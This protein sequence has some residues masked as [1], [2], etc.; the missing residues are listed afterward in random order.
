MATSYFIIALS[1]AVLI[2]YGFD[3]LS[4]RFRT[5][6]VLLLLMLGA[7][8]RLLTNSLGITVPFVPQT[9]STLGTL[10]LILIVLEGGLDL[11]IEPGRYGLIRRTSLMGLLS[12]VA[13]TLLLATLLYILLDESYYKCL[14]NTLPF[15]IISSS[16]AGQATRPLTDGQREFMTYETSFAAIISIMLY[17][18]LIV[19][20]Q[21][22]LTATFGFV[23]DTLLMGVISVIC[24]FALLYLIGRINHPVKFLP[25]IS[26][27]FLVYAIADIYELS[28]LVLVLIFGLFLNNTELFIRGRLADVFKSDLFERELDQLKN[29]TA[30]GAFIIRTFFFLLFGYSI[31]LATLIDTDAL[32]VSTLFV[33][34]ILAV[35]WPLLRLLYTADPRPLN[36]IA[37]RGLITILLYTNIPAALKLTGFREGILTLVVVLTAIIMAIG[38]IRYKRSDE[39]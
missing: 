14:I 35:R 1:T 31:N 30:E 34:L 38:T 2:S 33:I 18:F 24:C 37:P 17:N 27:L 20:D 10:A 15:S 6:P 28:S 22:I 16:I 11:N 21:S 5:P 7:G 3:L 4:S 12:I 19:S 26:V 36:W 32:I 23:R 13:T 39:R 8:A 29:L 25:I 9:L